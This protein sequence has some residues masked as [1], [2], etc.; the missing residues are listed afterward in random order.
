MSESIPDY[1][2]FDAPLIEEA[3]G[4][5]KKALLEDAQPQMVRLYGSIKDNCPV[6]GSPKYRALVQPVAQ[7]ALQIGVRFP[8]PHDDSAWLDGAIALTKNVKSLQR[9]NR[10]D[11]LA[12]LLAWVWANDR[13]CAK[14]V[15]SAFG[16]SIEEI[17]ERARKRIGNAPAPVL[18]FIQERSTYNLDN[19][20]ERA[21]RRLVLV[22]QNHW[23][24]IKQPEGSDSDFWPKIA[25]ALS[26]GVTVEIVAMHQ[27]VAQ[28]LSDFPSAD[29]IGV[30]SQ[31]LKADE[32][33]Q[34]VGLCW[35]TLNRFA[36]SY[37]AERDAIAEAA[38]AQKLRPGKLE[39]YRAWFLPMSLSFVDPESAAGLGVISPRTS[40]PISGTRAEFVITKAAHPD[41]FSH[42]WNFVSHGV[43]HQ[44]WSLAN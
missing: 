35:E 12:L 43:A 20:F 10:C 33:G 34:H 8:M 6:G 4:P 29:A 23:Y 19:L 42:Y 30:W 44:K 5:I 38:R 11:L 18:A 41:I 31:Y 17:E 40:S 16:L 32:F 24:M 21:K 26:R 37:T 3:L 14:D 39:I 27:D 22:A 15:L 9:G 13:P 7:I 36:A 25:A 28:P 1:S 2:L